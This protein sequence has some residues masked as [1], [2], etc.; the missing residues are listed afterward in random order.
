[1][2]K[3][4]LIRAVALDTGMTQKEVKEV[5]ESVLKTI[6]EQLKKGED[7]KIMRFA[8]FYVSHIDGMERQ[9]PKTGEPVFVPAHYAPRCR[10]SKVVKEEVK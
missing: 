9:N 6:V 4:E 5:L 2:T 7:V 10:F 3:T 1:M 8:K